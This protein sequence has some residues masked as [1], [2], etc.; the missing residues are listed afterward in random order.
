M[1][2]AQNNV[3][4]SIKEGANWED[5]HLLAER[6]IVKHLIKLGL[7]KDTDLQELEDKRIGALFFPHGLGHFFGTCVHDVGGYNKGCPERRTEAG[8]KSLRTRRQ[9]KAGMALTVEPGC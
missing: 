9:L 5:M 8:L 4:H 2:E 7:V 1:L 6:T 3:L